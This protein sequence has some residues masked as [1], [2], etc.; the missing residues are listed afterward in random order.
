MKNIFRC[1]FDEIFIHS[2]KK[3][4][5][6]FISIEWSSKEKIIAELYTT[7]CHIN[8]IDLQITVGRSEGTVY[9]VGC[10]RVNREGYLKVLELLK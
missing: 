9:E 1:G 10:V 8:K 4:G 5:K 2:A 6:K 7:I 3:V